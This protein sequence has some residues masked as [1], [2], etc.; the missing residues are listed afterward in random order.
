M[1][2]KLLVGLIVILMILTGC[3][4]VT[5]K[6]EEDSSKNNE[7]E[8]KKAIIVFDNKYRLVFNKGQEKSESDQNTLN[9]AKPLLIENFEKVKNKI[10]T[11]KSINIL[12]LSYTL[13]T[14]QN[15]K[16]I[17]FNLFIVNTS[18]EN[19]YNFKTDTIFSFVGNP[20][21]FSYITEMKDIG[22]DRLLN[23]EGVIVSYDQKITDQPEEYF[24]N[25]KLEDIN[26]NL[27]NIEI[28]NSK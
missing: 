9:D 8:I 17:S 2:Q 19:I 1:K 18:S 20:Y 10:N 26:I 28:E 21:E 15:G 27:S 3:H 11:E 6:S 24:N 7:D 22:M 25:L 12:P 4:N 23:N 5:N 14:N 13:T 16:F